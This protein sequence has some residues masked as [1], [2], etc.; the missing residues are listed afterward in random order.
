[1]I[2]P[3]ISLNCDYGIHLILTNPIPRI[4]REEMT[5]LIEMGITLVKLY[6]T[7]LP[8]KL[9]DD[10][11]LFVMMSARLLGLTIKVRAENS[12][13]IDLITT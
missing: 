4:M 11:L 5:K 8:M 6:M 3:R 1:M 13:I 12:D 7:Y 10:D 2:L 9:G